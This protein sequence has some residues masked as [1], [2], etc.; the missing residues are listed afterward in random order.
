MSRYVADFATSKSPDQVERVV[1]RYLSGE[2]FVQAAY[3]DEQVWQ[4]TKWF[5]NDGA[6]YIAITPSQDGVHLEA[7]VRFTILP[8]LSIGEIGTV[9]IFARIPMKRLMK[10]VEHLAQFLANSR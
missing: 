4:K 1:S 3:G 7:W 2:G 10:R 9:A 6:Q 5:S 8:G